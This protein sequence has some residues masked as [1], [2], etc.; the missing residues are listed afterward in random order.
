VLE[1]CSGTGRLTIPL[2]KSG[3]DIMGLDSSETMLEMARKKVEKANIQIHF[4]KGDMR[5]FDL[6]RKFSV[7]FIPFNSLQNTYTLKDVEFVFENIK[8][9]LEPGGIFIFDLFNPSIHIMVDREKE[10]VEGARF[11]LDD[12]REVVVK[13][14]CDYDSS[15]QVNRVKWLFKI[16]DEEKI[17][18]VDMRCFF[19]L[20]MD[21]ILKYNNFLIIEKFGS[22][23]E[24]P[25]DSQS[26]KQ[27]YFCST[28]N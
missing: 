2:K 6:K 3:I 11:H 18:K 23:D 14:K 24:N 1:L 7:I 9:H 21:A 15:S 22:F 10:F 20:E 19:P 27:I 28:S 5:H 8:N 12:G 4:E 26:Q 16:G 13:E 17:E 25:F